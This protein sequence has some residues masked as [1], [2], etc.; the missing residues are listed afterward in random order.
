MLGSRT[1]QAP[2]VASRMARLSRPAPAAGLA[3]A[4]R[5]GNAGSTTT[6]PTFP[7]PLITITGPSAP[8]CELGHQPDELDDWHRLLNTSEA[9]LFPFV[10]RI[11]VPT[12]SL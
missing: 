1:H 7:V 3:A 12:R 9:N 5:R 4:A 8:A 6:S 10:V 2:A 11:L